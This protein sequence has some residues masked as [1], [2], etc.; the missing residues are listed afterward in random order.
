MLKIWAV[1]LDKKKF[2]SY[3]Y[4]LSQEWTGFKIK[5]TSFTHSWTQFLHL[6]AI[7]IINNKARYNPID[8]K[9]WQMAL[10]SV[11]TTPYLECLVK[12]NWCKFRELCLHSRII[13]YSSQFSKR[14]WIVQQIGQQ[15]L[16]VTAII[17]AADQSVSWF[18]EKM[19]SGTALS[20][21]FMLV[22]VHVDPT[23]VFR[24]QDFLEWLPPLNF[25]PLG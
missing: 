17:L 24:F 21:L 22:L 5:T 12:Q 6:N 11:L 1:Y 2:Y 9:Y 23:S 19:K 7:D 10:R 8:A 15:P 13:C 20:A 4:E 16:Y 25:F 14:K 18:T 3:I